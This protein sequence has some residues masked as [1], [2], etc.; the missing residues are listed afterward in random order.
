MTENTANGFQSGT[1]SILP[2]AITVFGVISHV[3]L[4]IAYIKDPL[5]CFKN[6]GTYLM[7]NLAISDLLT[8]LLG[9]FAYTVP[10]ESY[11]ILQFLWSVT[12]SVSI[13]TITAISLDR[14]LMVVYPMKHRILMKGRTI[15]VWS[16][17]IWFGCIIFPV[18]DYF[19]STNNS[20]EIMT[21]FAESMIVIAVIMYALTYYKLKKQFNNL[22]LENFSNRQQQARN[23]KEKRFL[24]TITLIAWIAFICVVPSSLIYNYVV[25]KK[26]FTEGE[27]VRI[28]MAIFGGLYYLNFAVNPMVYVLRLPNYRKTFYLLYCCKKTARRC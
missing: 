28:L 21:F 25:Y 17:F 16:V 7:K 5:K 2:Y 26:W 11:W 13:I 4:I 20:I 22:A 23:I 24:K 15:F 8:C 10:Q 3:L 27:V 9:P 18:K 14:F 6:S 19:L 1:I 12:L